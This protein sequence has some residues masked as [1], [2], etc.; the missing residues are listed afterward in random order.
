MTQ[1]NYRDSGVDIKEGEKA[2]ALMKENVRDTFTK[3]VLSDLGHFGGLFQADFPGTENPV[4]VASTDGVGT[5]LK[6]AS[7]TLKY[8]TVGQDLVNHC[9]NDILVQGATPLFFM[10][11]IACGKLEASVVALI[12]HGL[13][14]ACRENGCALLGG[15]TAEMPGFY[16]EGDYDVAGTIIGLV[17]RSMIIDGS[18]I[19]PG[20]TI[21]G[22]PSNGLHTNGY[23]LA[24]KVLFEISQMSPEDR[25]ALLEGSSIGEALLAV[26]KSYLNVIKPLLKERVIRGIAHITGGGI[27]GN[28]SRILPEGCGAL[29]DEKWEIPGIF[30][31]IRECG[32]IDKVEMRKAFNMGA[33][34]LIVVE[35]SDSDRTLE[36]LQESGELPFLA[37]EITSQ[38]GI[39]FKS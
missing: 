5:K 11:Y 14:V 7:M 17:D 13:A 39:S 24:R 1:I 3:E 30:E 18:S 6:V 16:N 4:L 36:I 21:I 32:N 8:D 20:M 9:V 31:I 12:V 25:P 15:E 29:I 10:D 38:E 37:G 2:I 35:R 27:P 28:L 26:H 19:R 33:G 22:L 23:S 34:M